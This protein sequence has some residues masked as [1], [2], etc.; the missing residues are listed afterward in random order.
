MERIRMVYIAQDMEEFIG[1]N[2]NGIV[3]NILDNELPLFMR[4]C[5]REGLEILITSTKQ[6]GE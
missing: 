5:N 4:I 2:G 1:N 6:E 3:L